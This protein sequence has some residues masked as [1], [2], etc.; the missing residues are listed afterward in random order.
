[1]RKAV[2]ASRGLTLAEIVLA[3]GI[4]TF[5]ALAVI[6]VF[7]GL[8]KTSAK[9]REQAMA[10]L[11][12]ESLLERT[13]SS[14]PPGWG[15]EGQTAVRLEALL[16]EDGARFFYQVDPVRLQPDVPLAQPDGESWKVTVTVGWWPPDSGSLENSRQGFGELYVRGVRTVYLR[17]G[18]RV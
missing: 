15:V 17:D 1:M 18:D 4:L 7:L 10:E 16:Q 13:T 14:G 11:L 6:G 9:N 2:W 5:V 12:T 8:L 3:M